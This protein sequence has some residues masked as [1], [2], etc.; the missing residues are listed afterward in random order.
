MTIPKSGG[1]TRRANAADFLGLSVATCKRKERTDPLFPKP[2][3]ISDR[4]V[5]YRTT[6]LLA[7]AASRPAA[8]PNQASTA[9][10]SA[11]LAE[12]R[13]AEREACVP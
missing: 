4:C 7:W 11:A 13:R 2:V 9:A 1:L 6:E 5:G 12:K 10:A 3:V 8:L